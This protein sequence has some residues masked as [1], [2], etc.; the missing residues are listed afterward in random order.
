MSIF[1]TILQKTLGIITDK[2]FLITIVIIIVI[3]IYLGLFSGQFRKYLDTNWHNIRCKPYI[4]PIAGISNRAKGTNFLNRTFNNFNECSHSIISETISTASAPILSVVYGFTEVFKTISNI[5]NKFRSMAKIMR[6]LFKTLVES[7][8]DKASNLSAT[9]HFY[10]EKLKLIMRKQTAL[11]SLVHQFSGSLG[12]LMYSLVHGPI[13]NFI[14]FMKEFFYLFISVLAICLLCAVGGPFV[15]I[16]ACPLCAICFHPNTL[17]YTDNGHKYIGEIELGEQLYTGKVIST[18]EIMVKDYPLYNYDGILVTGDHLVKEKGRW[19]R[20]RDSS[21]YR[22]TIKYTGKL[23]CLNTSD[24]LI[25][26]KGHSEDRVFRD[27]IE[28]LDPLVT[29]DSKIIYRNS[30]NR[31]NGKLQTGYQYL[32]SI[33]LETLVRMND[34]ANKPIKDVQ[35]GDKLFCEIEV[36]GK[37]LIDIP[38]IEYYLLDG[39]VLSGTDLIENYGKYSFVKD[40]IMSIPIRTNDKP[41]MGIQGCHLITDMGLI[42][43]GKNY[44]IRDYTISQNEKINNDLDSLVENFLNHNR[45]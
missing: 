6:D 15:D 21:I 25:A 16:I 26:I 28:T 9:L 3:Y 45:L 7:V 27:F 22:V 36:L 1:Q 18:F 14:T 13:P 34:G 30:L 38:N 19:I 42:P 17:V 12:F 23:H 8:I 41:T 35:V 11:F 39:M 20:V 4:I 24:N 37:V 5:I 2:R 10:I 43:V 32:H 33:G 29:N 31:E 44:F 40:H